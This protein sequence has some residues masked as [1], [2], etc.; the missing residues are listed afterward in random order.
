M[1]KTR[2]LLIFIAFT[3]ILCL[4]LPMS[5]VFADPAVKSA[6]IQ[7]RDAIN[8]VIAGSTLYIAESYAAFDADLT[9]LGGIAH[10]DDVIASDV[11]LQD[12][13]DALTVSLTQLRTNLVTKLV[14]AAINYHF[15][16]AAAQSLVLYTARSQVLY[17]AELDR[18]DAILNNPRSGDTVVLALEPQIDDAHDLLILLADKTALNLA[19]AEAN[20]IATSDG[21]I[22]TPDSFQ[23]FLTAFALFATESLDGYGM[24]VN[25]I[26]EL[27]DASVFEA[28][29]ALNVIDAEISKLDLR[30]DKT[31]ILSEYETA[32]NFPI[33]GYTPNSQDLFHGEL[34]QI[35][36]A[37]D[38]PNTL[39][40]DLLTISADLADIY[41]LL[42]PLAD[43][44]ALID[45]NTLSILAYYEEREHYTISSYAAFKAAVLDYGTYLFINTVIADPNIHQE[46]VD[47]W[48]TTLLAAVALLVERADVTLLQ[49]EYEKL[50]NLPLDTMTPASINLFEA[51][52]DRITL[53]LYGRDTDQPLADLTLLEAKQ[54]F[55]L[56]VLLADK[57]E[58]TSLLLDCEDLIET[59]YSLT[60]YGSLKILIDSAATLLEDL[61]VTQTAIDDLSLMI[62]GAIASLRPTLTPVAIDE[63]GEAVNINGYVAIGQSSIV[64]YGVSDSSIIQVDGFGNVSGLTYGEAYV[65]VTLENGLYEDVP[66]V[67]KARIKTAAFVL[68]LTLPF[69]SAGVAFGLLS[70]NIKPSTMMVKIKKIKRP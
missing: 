70:S 21:T 11:V 42:V 17:Q 14:H 27:A 18:I 24:T 54:A 52:I 46:T 35:K 6:L 19:L 16:Q 7:E 25:Q 66:I 69:V 44:T 10:I 31:A 43:K 13:V 29:A 32:F 62:E 30:P 63:D 58:L 34:V 36:I 26:V 1:I 47:G 57:S 45:A 50:T 53:I 48:T 33:S 15:Q 67:V 39:E 28:E 38:D 12:E 2:K 49:V 9:L 51:E 23:A 55:E 59:D 5:K 60:S 65:R 3:S 68:V 40:T 20:A 4:F 37:I 64:S 56:L 8:Q 22:Y 61:N 41:G